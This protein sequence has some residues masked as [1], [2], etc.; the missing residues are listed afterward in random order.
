MLREPVIELHPD[1]CSQTVRHRHHR[2]HPNT[3]PPAVAAEQ[4][5]PVGG[6]ACQWDAHCE[7]W[8]VVDVEVAA[9]QR[10]LEL[11]AEQL[12]PHA[13]EVGLALA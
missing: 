8:P 9:E 2:R 12:A 7:H 6:Q 11:V 5:T 13:S 10:S 1:L 3:Q 4:A